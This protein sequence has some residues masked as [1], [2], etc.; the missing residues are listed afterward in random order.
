[1][2]RTQTEQYL[3][4]AL[5]ALSD[6]RS[7]QMELTGEVRWTPYDYGKDPSP[8]QSSKEWESFE[9]DQTWGGKDLHFCFDTMVTTPAQAAGKN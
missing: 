7:E 4:T 5:S 1:M 9:R 8:D 2:N 6:L 3:K